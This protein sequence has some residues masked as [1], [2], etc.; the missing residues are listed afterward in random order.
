MAIYTIAQPIDY[1][2]EIPF[3]FERDIQLLIEQNISTLLGLNFIRSEFSLNNF[4]IDTLAFDP[5]NKSFIIIE[6]KRDKNFSVIDQGYAYL[7]LMLNNKADF[8]L[9]YNESLHTSLK[10]SDVDWTQSKVIFISPV[11]TNYQKEAINFR[12]LPIELWEIKKYEN[13][14]ILF[15]QIQKT[16]AKESIKTISGNNKIVEEVTKE[17]KVYNEEDHI[18]KVDFET[19]ELY[20]AVKERIISLD[21]NISV[22]PKKQTIGFKVDNNIFC[23]II[24]QGK[25]LKIYLNL[26]SNDLQDQKKIARDVSNV[27]HW[28]NGSYE[29]KLADLDDIDYVISLLKQSLRKNKKG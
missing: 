6:Y 28:G 11:F 13:N 9:E 15:E 3:R 18:A 7:S 25:G 12:D 16:T 22:Q 8:I 24:L 19:R 21:E 4:R 29:I 20:E 27:G 23:D 1:V 5:E 10:R 2:K 17:V 26:K 14:T